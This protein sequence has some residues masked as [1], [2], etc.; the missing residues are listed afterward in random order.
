[1]APGASAMVFRDSGDE[2]QLN[3]IIAGL[4]GAARPTSVGDVASLLIPNATSLPRLSP[5]GLPPMSY[6]PT[7][8]RDAARS[9]A[10]ELQNAPGTGAISRFVARLLQRIPQPSTFQDLPLAQQMEH[11]PMDGPVPTS[12]R[13]GTPPFAPQPTAPRFNDLPLAQQMEQLPT[14][15]PIPETARTG[16]PPARVTSMAP[17]T[18]AAPRI[19]GKTPS[20]E[21][22]LVSAMDEIRKGDVPSAGTTAPSVTQ[23]ATGK[24]SVTAAQYD[25]MQ[26]KAP[27]GAPSR[28]R[29]PE[30]APTSP[31]PHQTP[32][33][34][35]PASPIRLT[36]DE[37]RA[38]ADLVRQGY[39][40]PEVVR[41]ILALRLQKTSRAFAAL[42][43]AREVALA[44]ADRNETGRWK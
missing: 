33:A 32:A 6:E 42:P 5:K 24:P 7:P 2:P 23:T 36:P 13:M 17:V 40:E 41:G 35:S 10:T 1:M 19:A 43:D 34:Q 22:S 20:L 27:G 38:K 11:L 14:N 28:A 18:G 15:G 12:A 26:G 16:G 8:I 9:F 30:R 39:P 29:T 31:A 3:P 25:A 4:Q 21:D 37:V 44:V